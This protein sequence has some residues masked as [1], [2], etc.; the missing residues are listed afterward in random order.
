[1]ILMFIHA[2][3]SLIHRCSHIYLTYN[4]GLLCKYWSELFKSVTYLCSSSLPTNLNFLQRSNLR[5]WWQHVAEINDTCCL[6]GYHCPC[7]PWNLTQGSAVLVQTNGKIQQLVL[8]LFKWSNS[9]FGASA[10]IYN[11][12]CLE[13]SW[14][15]STRSSLISVYAFDLVNLLRQHD[16]QINLYIYQYESFKILPAEQHQCISVVSVSMS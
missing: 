2:A 6:A 3:L 7:W 14:R 4:T 8:V 15:I 12:D 5:I 13:W 1:M 9:S 11:W 10:I 16:Q